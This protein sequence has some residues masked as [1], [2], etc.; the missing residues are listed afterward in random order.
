MKSV[1]TK[2]YRALPQSISKLETISSMEGCNFHRK[3]NIEL[4]L[5]SR[6]D[7][8]PDAHILHVDIFHVPWKSP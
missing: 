8:S 3:K 6:Q 5:I 1:I 2:D 7:K 4:I